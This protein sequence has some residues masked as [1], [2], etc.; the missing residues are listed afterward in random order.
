MKLMLLC[1][2]NP[3]AS[4]L[5]HYILGERSGESSDPFFLLK[6][7]KVYETI[8][9]DGRVVNQFA[10]DFYVSPGDNPVSIPRSSILYFRELEQ[11]NDTIFFKNYNDALVSGRLQQ[12]GIVSPGQK[13]PQ[14]TAN[15]NTRMG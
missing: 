14:P 7:I 11:T 3:P 6:P 4:C 1:L 9:Q 5:S 13:A 15:P 2:K 12:A 8:S 10:Y